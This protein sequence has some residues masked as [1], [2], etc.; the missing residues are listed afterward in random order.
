MKIE[1]NTLSPPLPKFS[2]YLVIVIILAGPEF[3]SMTIYINVMMSRLCLIEFCSIK[4]SI[5][6]PLPNKRQT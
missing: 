4:A 6:W 5:W 3:N 2:I 1:V